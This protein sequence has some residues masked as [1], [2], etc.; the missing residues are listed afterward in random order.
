MKSIDLLSCSFP[1]FRF[2]KGRGQIDFE[3][4]EKK[5][6]ECDQIF[7]VIFGC[8]PFT[9][10]PE[11]DVAVYLSDKVDSAIKEFIAA[12][13]LAPHPVS[14]G[15]VD[16]HSDLLFDLVRGDNESVS[17]YAL[18]VRGLIEQD[19]EVRIKESDVSKTE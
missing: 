13:L 11:N 2:I 10:L 12:N 18:R 17:D 7:D 19:N 14:E 8:N 5:K 4:V 3:V 16:E 6:D 9:R 1:A 15:V